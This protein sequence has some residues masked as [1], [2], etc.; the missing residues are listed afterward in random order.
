MTFSR[1]IIITIF[2]IYRS[3]IAKSIAYYPH[4]KYVVIVFIGESVR[5][6]TDFTRMI[7]SV[8]Q[9]C[10]NP[11]SI[12]L[13]CFGDNVCLI[14]GNRHADRRTIYDRKLS[15]RYLHISSILGSFF[16]DEC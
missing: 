8:R 2:Q 16:K 9:K 1:I 11:L 5:I 13:L 12:V 4:F 15:I 14:Y 10:G 7:V 3:I 6:L